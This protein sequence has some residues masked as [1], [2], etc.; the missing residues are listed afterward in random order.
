MLKKL[1][2]GLVTAVLSL[3]V[4]VLVASPASA[5]HNTI[6]A[7]VVCATD[8]TYKVTWSVTNSESNKTEKITQSNM[9]GVVAVGTQLGFSE[10]K[11]FV[12][13]VTEPQNLELVLTGF[14][15]GDTSTTKDDVYNKDSGWFGKDSFPKGCL[16]VTPEATD[17]PSVCNGPNTYT[18]PTYTLKSVPGIKYT[19]DG[20]EKAPGTY[21]ATNG[22]TV[23]IVATVT[24]PK[25]TIEGKSTWTFTFTKPADGTCVVKTEPVKP[26]VALQ[27]CTAPGEY[28]LARYFVPN[29]TGVLYSV[30]VN[31]AETPLTKNQWYE[32]PDGT[33]TVQIIARPDSANYYV[34]KDGTSSTTYDLQFND[35]GDCV[36]RVEPKDPRVVTA[37]CDVVNHPGVVP[38]QS[39]TLF[40]VDHVI[41]LVS[42]NGGPAVETVVTQDT[43]VVVPPGTTVTITAKSDDPAKYQS[44]P[45]WTFTKA[46][47]DPGD[48]KAEI[49]PLEPDWT[50]QFCDDSVDPRVV[51][52]GAVVITPVAGLTYYLDGAVVPNLQ[53]GVASTIEVTPGLH[54]LTV[55]V[56]DPSKY[57]LADGVDLP[58][59]RTIAAGECLPTFPLLTPATSSNQIGCFTAGS[60]TLSNDLD[61]PAAVTW[62]VNGSQVAE[63]KYTVTGSGTVT[64][65]ATANG[66]D[67]GFN[68]GVQTSWTYDFKKPTVCDIETLALTGQNPTGLLIA[69]D[70]LVVAGLAL[71]AMR[72]VRR[73]RSQTA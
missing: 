56:D 43:K 44:T 3:G 47:T 26:D 60:Y 51:V 1:L 73:G 70:L 33:T 39:Y 41:Y 7:K 4:V 50:D 65:T 27:E 12:Q 10:T 20:S 57:K 68:P 22:T 29:T 30:V 45:G 55:T 32:V 40:P 21:D 9:P 14:W 67:Y 53:V 72:A 34:F 2:A 64:I 62:T 6:S 16:K 71:F 63:G 58:F 17:Q 66:P 42:T 61:D 37:T 11:T 25:Y 46:F 18:T 13:T 8:G 48:C 28:K 5:H 15:D 19:V 54:Q 31:G 23:T 52:E 38:E 49:T 35:I 59:E 24:D 36:Q 69:A